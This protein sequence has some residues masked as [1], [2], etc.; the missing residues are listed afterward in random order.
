MKMRQIRAMGCF[1]VVALVVAGFAM[2]ALAQNRPNPQD[3]NDRD[4]QKTIQRLREQIK[5]YEEVRAAA[6]ERMKQANEAGEQVQPQIEPTEKAMRDGKEQMEAQQRKRLAASQAMQEKIKEDES[7]AAARADE[8][9]AEAKRDAVQEKLMPA[10]EAESRYKQLAA[11]R[12]A[13]AAALEKA[14]RERRENDI[15][16]AATDLARDQG[17]LGTYVQDKLNADADYKAAADAL[18]EAQLKRRETE[19]S[20]SE[21]YRAESGLDEIDAAYEAQQNAYRESRE[22]LRDLERKLK[23]LSSEYKDAAKDADRAAKLI[24]QTKRRI[25][26]LRK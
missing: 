6:Q 15:P 19:K 20:V 7:I 5:E 22:K 2:P 25:E 4:V 9:Q 3:K 21:R 24:D 1:V 11:K 26:S 18:D 10:I 23:S 12:D 17:E 8:E 13:S 16:R 14:K